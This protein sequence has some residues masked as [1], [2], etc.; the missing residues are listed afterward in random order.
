[1]RVGVVL[2][3]LIALVVPG[4]ASASPVTEVLAG[5]TLSGS[6]IPC[7]T[8]L[9]GVR[10]CHGTDGGATASDLRLRT[11]DGVPL[12][13]YLILPPAPNTGIDGNYPL[14][15]QSHGYGARPEARTTASTAVPPPMPGPSLGTRSCS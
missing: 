12:E 14:I 15:I 13:V 1:M 4:A 11:F 5:H 3:A 8:Q 9:D 6:A 7:S 10:V 2:A